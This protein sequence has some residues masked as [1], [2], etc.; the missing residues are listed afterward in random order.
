MS[1]IQKQKDKAWS[2]YSLFLRK[3][4]KIITNNT[5]LRVALNKKSKLLQMV[6]YLSRLF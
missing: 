3:I 5:N 1:D 6:R 4:G 2:I